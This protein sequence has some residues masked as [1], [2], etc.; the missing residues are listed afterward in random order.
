MFRTRMVASLLVQAITRAWWDYFLDVWG[1]IA[2]DAEARLHDP[3]ARR[4][5]AGYHQPSG[6]LW[7]E[8]D[9]EG[10]SP[11]GDW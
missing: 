4:Y 3:Y 9:G 6:D 7:T 2:E 5:A 1:V 11:S 10:F 8:P